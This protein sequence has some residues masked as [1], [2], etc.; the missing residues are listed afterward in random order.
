MN[1]DDE[2]FGYDRMIDCLERSRDL[3]LQ[4]SIERLLE[5]VHAW[6]GSETRDDDMSV[7]ALEVP[8]SA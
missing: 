3:N 1:G 8:A 2:M 4:A 6:T 7:V 5:A